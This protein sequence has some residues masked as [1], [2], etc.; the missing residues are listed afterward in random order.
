MN[1]VLYGGFF[2]CSKAIAPRQATATPPPLAPSLNYLR[3]EY[4]IMSSTQE[5]CTIESD[6]GV[7]TYLVESLGVHGVEFEE[8]WSLDD[9]SLQH[10]C[11]NGN[12]YG[13][14]FLF[15]WQASEVEDQRP[16]LEEMEILQHDLFFAKQ[17]VTN[18][19]ATQAILSVI[20]NSPCLEDD[21][22]N[23]SPES[24][25]LI[26]LGP[27]LSTFKAFTSSFP[28]DL[29]GMAIGG[30]EEIR[31]AHNSFARVDPFISDEDAKKNTMIDN[32]SNVFHFIAYIPKNGHVYEIDGLKSG[33]VVVGRYMSTAEQQKDECSYGGAAWLT[34]A[35][36]AI[37]ERIE[38]FSSSEIK[39]NLMA[40]I[41]DRR[42]DLQSS[43]ESLLME[44]TTHLND[45]DAM[46]IREQLATLEE[47]RTMWKRE[48]ERRR[49]NYL[50]FCVE[51]LKSLARSGKLT[52]ITEE[53]RKRVI[54][55]SKK[56]KYGNVANE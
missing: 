35:R 52:Q 42:I 53:A 14:I 39:F 41:R 51:L 54:N 32:D 13:L 9:D 12:V 21:E 6:P 26:Q 55:T 16:T 34:V 24:A 5:W 11:Q 37:Q 44:K 17:T 33:P 15:K 7:F 23:T 3:R 1:T 49:H 19:C 20:L 28:P 31:N 43:L 22:R 36:T 48:N 27:V 25:P 46:I 30:S 29:K 18:A 40:V 56:R 45:E 8:L 4:A 10:L 50:P 2:R 38:R 47:R